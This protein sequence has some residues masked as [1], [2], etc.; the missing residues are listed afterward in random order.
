MYDNDIALIELEEPLTFSRNLSAVCLPSQTLEV[1]YMSIFDDLKVFKITQFYSCFWFI[2]QPTDLCVTAGWGFPTNGDINLELRMFLPV[3]TYNSKECNATSNYGGFI[4]N[5]SICAGF[6]DKDKGPCYVS[7]KK[8]YYWHVHRKD[9]I[10]D[11]NLW[12]NYSRMMKGH[13]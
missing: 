3:P 5:S 6:K 13:H 8:S 1:R 2:F 9:Y 10:I 11:C 7:L 12:F 4:S